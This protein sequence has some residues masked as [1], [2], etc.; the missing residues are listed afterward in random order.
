VQPGDGG[1]GAL[2]FRREK[3]IPRGGPDGG[4]GGAGGSVR[5][6]ASEQLST[7][8][9]YRFKHHW[10]AQ[11][12]G[13]GRGNHRHGSSGA[14][15][16]LEVP[17]GTLVRDAETSEVLADLLEPGGTLVV[18]RGGRGGRGNARFASSTQQAP[19]FSE[20]GEPGKERWLWLEL[21]LVADVGLV[22]QPN[23]GKSSLLAALSAAHPKIAPYPF[24][25]LE[26]QLG[27]VELAG[28]QQ[29][30]L[31]DIPGLIEGA[32]SGAGLGLDFLRHIERVRVLCHVLD[33]ELGAAE[34]V[35][36]LLQ[37]YRTVRQELQSYGAGLDAK[38]EVVA[39]NKCDLPGVS[40]LLPG[41][42]RALKL[43]ERDCFGVSALTRQGCRELAQWLGEV[44]QER[45][46]AEAQEAMSA[47][48][49]AEKAP[50]V[51]R[52]PERR[53]PFVVERR[54]VAFVVH[55]EQ[56]ERWVR[57]TDLNQPDGVRRLQRRLERVG[58]SAALAEAGAEAG[59]T[60][61]IAG[62][63]FEYQP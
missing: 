28:Y 42:R 59:A 52:G 41:L 50:R 21:K 13:P 40:G 26:P 5:V 12:G 54:D 7:L 20:K 10:R 22:G 49:E 30:V 29:M 14:D 11:P 36:G 18:A 58:V 35:E 31:A 55:G 19:R 46:L 33:G 62:F 45:R 60:V 17:C 24:T 37:A 8:S 34:G 25:T 4:D 61:N 23:A 27:V 63:V 39:L 56:V 43:S 48:M 57:T 32:S 2:S 38:A 53:A 6:V 9:Q 51:Y 47:D 15:L 16:V 1:G 3:Y 44:V